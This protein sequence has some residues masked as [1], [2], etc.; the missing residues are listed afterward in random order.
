MEVVAK[1][2]SPTA[3]LMVKV[4]SRFFINPKIF[5]YSV[6][7]MKS[8][9]KQKFLGMRGERTDGLNLINEWI[10][11]KNS[12]T[13]FFISSRDGLLK[14]NTSTADHVLGLFSENHLD[15]HLDGNRNQPTLREMTKSAIE[16]LRKNENG[17]VLFVEAGRIDHGHHEVN[18]K[19]LS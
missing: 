1:N 12:P 4:S 3:Q 14:L 13:A 9:A 8:F 5:G 18:F 11:A 15:Y 16:I 19:F 2:L 7:F 17:F 10:T 6:D